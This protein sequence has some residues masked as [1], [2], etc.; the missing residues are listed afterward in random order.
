MSDEESTSEEEESDVEMVNVLDINFQDDGSDCDDGDFI[1]DQYVERVVDK[2]MQGPSGLCR[3]KITSS[4]DDNDDS[5]GEINCER[6]DDN[7]EMEENGYEDNDDFDEDEDCDDEDLEVDPV[8]ISSKEEDNIMKLFTDWLQG[9][10]GGL[11]PKREDNKHRMVCQRI[12]RENKEGMIMPYKNL[13]SK[14]Y[15]RDWIGFS[16]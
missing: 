6:E 9:I 11:K 13:L 5:D 4:S 8:L 12:L 14:S 7:T 15:I 1:A 10:D 16:R 2:A 3:G